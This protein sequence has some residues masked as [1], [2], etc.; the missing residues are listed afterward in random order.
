MQ[1][2][3]VSEQETQKCTAGIDVSKNWLDAHVLPAAESLR[4]AN[5][6][7]GI[8]KLK[9]WLLEREVELPPCATRVGGK[10]TVEFPIWVV[11]GSRWAGAAPGRVGTK[12]K[13]AKS[14]K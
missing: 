7:E 10:G 12:W 6:R 14:L 9:R 13:A 3:E 5:T 4:V 8:R 2:K 1:G 11:L